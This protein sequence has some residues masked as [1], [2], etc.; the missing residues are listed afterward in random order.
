MVFEVEEREEGDK[1][2]I[3]GLKLSLLQE[4]VINPREQ[5]R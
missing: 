4:L 3:K 1:N 5:A 2:F